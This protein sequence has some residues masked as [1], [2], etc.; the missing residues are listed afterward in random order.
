MMNVLMLEGLLE[1]LRKR[2][3]RLKVCLEI[4]L[5]YIILKEKGKI[6]ILWFSEFIYIWRKKWDYLLVVKNQCF[7]DSA[8]E[9]VKRKPSF[10]LIKTT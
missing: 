4:L 9:A 6:Q 8:K 5:K 3:E 2:L 7:S 1:M 10:V